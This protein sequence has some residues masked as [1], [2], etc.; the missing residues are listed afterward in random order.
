MSEQS[1]ISGMEALR[2]WRN[3][4][5][6]QDSRRVYPLGT[7]A[8]GGIEC[9]PGQILLLGGPPGAGKTGLAMQGTVDALRLCTDVRA[10]VCNVEMPPAALLE[11]Q[12]ARLS[13]VPLTRIRNRQ[14]SPEEADVMERAIATL[15]SIASRLSFLRPPF[16]LECVARGADTVGANLIVLDYLQRFRIGE[17]EE[18]RHGVN[19]LMDMLRQFADAGMAI[20][21]LSAVGRTRDSKGR[22]SYAGEGLNLASFRESS[23]IEFGADNAYIL[24]DEDREAST[25][26]LR[27]LKSRYGECRDIALHFNRPIQ[28]FEDVDSSEVAESLAEPMEDASSLDELGTLWNGA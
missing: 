6:C 27:H 10:L 17:G 14:T 12:I 26:L 19:R 21:V 1:V 7:S 28:R 13:G 20:M 15:E 23:E 11:R 16:E 5:T 2:D 3:D 8:L 9:A 4:R 18:A 25:V 22:S 24:H